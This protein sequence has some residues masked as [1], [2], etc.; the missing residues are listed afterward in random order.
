[1]ATIQEKKTPQW[2]GCE[3]QKKIKNEKKNKETQKQEQNAT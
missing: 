1:M 3:S 2:G